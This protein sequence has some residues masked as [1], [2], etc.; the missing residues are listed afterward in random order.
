MKKIQ[1]EKENCMKNTYG[2]KEREKG[3]LTSA[4]GG[5]RK[6]ETA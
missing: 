2:E 1:K 3:P 6:A 4:E 5:E